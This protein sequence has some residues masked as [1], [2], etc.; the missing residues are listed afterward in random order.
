[1]HIDTSSAWLGAGLA[2]C[3]QYALARGLTLYRRRQM[4][5]ALDRL[6]QPRQGRHEEEVLLEQ[7]EVV[8]FSLSSEAEAEK[9]LALHPRARRVLPEGRPLAR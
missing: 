6:A 9:Y 5:R 4:M 7:D 3:F 8:L 1:M 2:L